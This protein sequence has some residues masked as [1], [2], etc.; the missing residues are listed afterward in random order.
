MVGVA[1]WRTPGLRRVATQPR[2]D[3]AS[4]SFTAL[5]EDF[6]T[7]WSAPTTDARLKKRI[8]RTVIHEA[9]ADL[10]DAT[11]EIVLTIHWVGGNH[12]QHRCR[13]DGGDSATARLPMPSRLCAP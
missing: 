4:I 11:S 10:D 12:T 9:M 8:V 5:A 7:V 3:L 2:S 13:A 1:A 6:Q